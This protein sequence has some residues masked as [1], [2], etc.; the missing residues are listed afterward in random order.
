MAHRIITMK[1]TSAKSTQNVTFGNLKGG[2]LRLKGYQIEG[3]TVFSP[4]FI[5]FKNI[6]VSPS[7]NGTDNSAFAPAADS[8]S[9]PIILGNQNTQVGPFDYG[10][11]LPEPLYIIEGD[12]YL[13]ETKSFDIEVRDFFN[14]LATF[15]A[16]LL[17]F[18]VTMPDPRNAQQ[19]E[20]R[21]RRQEQSESIF[22]NQN[23]FARGANS[24]QYPFNRPN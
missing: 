24:E 15:A 14:N 16:L 22:R 21:M 10:A 3:H 23:F 17:I 18:E 13:S 4:L 12:S 1:L 5:S 6:S 9:F 11:W 7:T 8:N 19:G 20:D 2:N